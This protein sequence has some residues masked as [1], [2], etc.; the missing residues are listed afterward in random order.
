MKVRGRNR[1]VGP[2]DENIAV[3]RECSV[4][5]VRTEPSLPLFMSIY[6]GIIM[7]QSEWMDVEL[8]HTRG[9]PPLITAA[10]ASCNLGSRNAEGR[11]V[12]SNLWAFC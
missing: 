4:G 11:A 7:S 8:G 6:P 5:N 9:I 2:D 12:G 1:I 3:A 10:F